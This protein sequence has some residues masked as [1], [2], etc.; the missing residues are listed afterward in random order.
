MKLG[1]QLADD[2]GLISLNGLYSG[3]HLGTNEVVSVSVS[4]FGTAPQSNFSITYQINN[5]PLISETFSSVLNP[6]DTLSY[7][8]S[9][10]VDL[11]SPGAYI[12]DAYTDLLSDG[13]NNNDSIVSYKVSNT[14]IA[15]YCIFDSYGGTGSVDCSNFSENLCNDGFIYST[16]SSTSYSSEP[17]YLPI[18]SIDSISFN[19][20]FTECNGNSNFI[21]LIDEV[22]IDTFFSAPAPCSCEPVNYPITHTITNSNILNTLDCGFHTFEVKSYY[23][24]NTDLYI[25]GYNVEVFGPCINSQAADVG[26]VG[27][28]SPYSG[29]H[30]TSTDS[31]T[32]L[33]KNFGNSVQSNIPLGYTVNGSNTAN[34]TF[35][36]SINP[37]DTTSYTFSTTADFSSPGSHYL[38]GFTGLLSDTKT[39][40]DTFYNYK[41]ENTTIATFPFKEDFE[42]YLTGMS[43]FGINWSNDT[44]GTTY[45]Q[46]NNGPTTSNFTGPSGDHT[47]GSGNYL[48]IEATGNNYSSAFLNSGCTD[49]SNMSQPSLSYWYHMYGADIYWLALQI[50][51][52]GTGWITLDVIYYQVQTS[53]SDKWNRVT[54]DLSAYPNMERF[55]FYGYTGGGYRS[56]IAIDDIK[57]YEEHCSNGIKDVDEKE[58]DC[59]GEDCASCPQKFQTAY[60]GSNYEYGYDVATTNDGGYI[61]VGST[62]SYGQGYEDILLVKTDSLGDTLWTKTYGGPNVD[63]GTRVIQTNDGGYLI[64]GYT[65]SYGSGNEDALLIK[66]DSQG[67]TLWSNVY[68]GSS[69]DKIFGMSKSLDGGYIISGKSGWSGSV[70]KI[71]SSG[72][73]VW[74]KQYSSYYNLRNINQSSDSSLYCIGNYYGGNYDA[75][76]LTLNHSN[77]NVIWAKS[78]GGNDN[79]YGKS[80]IQTSDGGYA[81]TGIT[82][83]FGSG[84]ADMFFAKTD[85][86]GN[87]T[88]AKA[89]GNTYYDYG[90]D[91]IETNSGNYTLTG[92]HYGNGSYGWGYYPILLTIDTTGNI[93][94]SKAYAPS[95]SSNSFCSLEKTIDNGFV[96][97]GDVTG[98]SSGESDLYLIKTDSLGQTGLCAESTPNI[99]VSTNSFFTSSQSTSQYTGTTTI[100]IPI[101]ETITDID[102]IK[103]APVEIT[104]FSI[105]N[106]SCFGSSNGTAFVNH[107][108]GT[109]PYYYSWSQIPSGFVNSIG[110]FAY[111]LSSGNYTVIVSAQNAC[112]SIDTVFI[113]QPNAPID[114]TESIQPSICYGSSDGQIDLVVSGGTAPYSYSWSN[115]ESSFLNDSL[116]SGWYQ[117]TVTDTNN[118]DDVFYYFVSEPP[119]ITSTYTINT[120]SCNGNSDG[121]INMSTSNGI[122]PFSYIW[123]NSDT[124]ED[125]SNL[126]SGVYFVT[127]TDSTNC[128]LEDSVFVNQPDSFIID[129]TQDSTSC[130]S[131]CDGSATISYSGGTPPYSALWNDPSS[132]TTASASNLCTGTYTV[133]VTDNNGCS[134]ADSIQVLEPYVLS[135]TISA[136]DISCNF[137]GDGTATI[138]PNGGTLP[139]TYTWSNGQSSSTAIGLFPG[140]YSVNVF[141]ANSCLTSNVASISEPDAISISISILDATCNNYDGSLIADVI[142][143]VSPYS[144]NWSTGSQTSSSNGLSGGNYNLT[145]TDNNG[146]IDSAIATLPVSAIIQD[147]CIVTVDSSS[148]MNEVVWEKPVVTNIDSFKIY[149][150]ISGNYSLVGTQPYATE[151]Y[152]TDS[153][154]GIN[155]QVT[156]Y[157]YKVST[158]DV[159]GN[160][161]ELSDFHETMHLQINYTGGVANLTWDS[162]EG[163]NTTFNYRILRDSTGIGAYEAIDSV[164]NNN[165]TYTDIAPPN[166][167]KYQVEVVH[168]F[169]GCTADKMDKDYNSAKSNTSTAIGPGSLFSATTTSTNANTGLCD[170]TATVTVTG[171][172]APY[173]YQWDGNANNQI[174][175]TATDLCP[176]T[177]S[178]TVYDYKANEIIVFANVGTIPGIL[179]PNENGELLNVFPNPYSKET[180]LSYNL[181]ENS[182]VTIELFNS[183][184]EK[185]NVIAMEDQLAGKHTYKINENTHNES[186]GVYLIKLKANDRIFI[187]RL[188]QLR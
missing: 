131:F 174:T 165:F 5:G 105:S 38:D 111:G 102:Y 19:L 184:G 56:D 180:E 117:V 151:S 80:V 170:G 157:R 114:A 65:A 136:T 92:I 46:T 44:I 15:S 51:T 34:E 152:F 95:N 2:I 63:V 156:S 106:A 137:G 18:G 28:S 88:V 1:N 90:Y 121:G 149:R 134:D 177:Y 122:A 181:N 175:Q 103:L 172:T 82:Y 148:S 158:L 132:Q 140:N 115:G 22:P 12:F 68:G 84:S 126:T 17:S 109:A 147:I 178:I 118:C 169:G 164:T 188:I 16:D 61:L 81:I 27:F 40:N 41:F 36:G 91:I 168:P 73:T 141:D 128:T 142:G 161:S 135:S 99:I 21:F 79:D 120:V 74:A 116:S 133:I 154:N 96:I 176:G 59:G 69:D 35:T 100:S 23:S 112:P 130:N 163:F 55:R 127:I 93:L 31:V 146:C 43:E 119:A 182:M 89:Y 123:S 124:T 144:Y 77:G 4:N 107:T 62:E 47:S 57:I 97:A 30:L 150:E 67:D 139:Y 173:T 14:Y 162:Y 3:C 10:T 64:G 13:D 6:G 104:D 29:C 26:I 187:K 48:Y 143:G 60:G 113:S 83:S 49:I 167:S 159:C 86:L 185:I 94:W 110:D 72:S 183:I 9:T 70:I 160:E 138:T 58:V 50:D 37:G 39:C 75:L 186:N 87:V 153:T 155:P 66:T 78:I 166:N 85:S 53:S 108:G 52:G 45:W 7:T 101:S 145:I 171:G 179:D 76:L 42:S 20:F 33:I 125:I 32:V 8:F 25:A 98:F 129:L 11:S 24:G 71:D 54:I